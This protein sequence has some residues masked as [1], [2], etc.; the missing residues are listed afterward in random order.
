M[1]RQA[2]ARVWVRAGAEGVVI[3]GRRKERLD[4]TIASLGELNTGTT[5]T[6][7][8]VTDTT[9]EADTN[10]LFA[11]VNE[12]FGRAADVVFANAGILSADLPLAE[13]NVRAW[14]SALVSFKIVHEA[15][16]DLY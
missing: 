15:V 5:R 6:L 10:H 12:T 13:E 4:E 2:I 3:A 9:K 7:A 11:R 14:W 1:C 16:Q 8:V